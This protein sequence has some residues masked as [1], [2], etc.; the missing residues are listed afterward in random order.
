M[1]QEQLPEPHGN[2][3]LKDP[4]VLA[5]LLCGFFEPAVR[6]L[7]IMD[8]L[9]AV[10]QVQEIVG[11]SRLAKST[12][13][14]AIKRFD[15]SQ[16]QSV[17]RILQ[18][19]MSPLTQCDPELAGIVRTI[20]Q[21]GTSIRLAGDVAWAF[22]RRRD[23]KGRKDSQA[24]VHLQVD[25]QRWTMEDFR[26]TGRKD[27]SEQAAM[28]KMLTPGTLYLMDRGYCGFDL[29]NEILGQGCH[30]V[31]RLKKDIVFRPQQSRP[32]SEKDI[33][34]G[35]Q[36]DEL[37]YLGLEDEDLSPGTVRKN[38]PP[39]QLM[40]RVQV[41]DPLN[42][43]AVILITDLLVVEAWV[44]GGLYRSR[45]I[46]ELYLRWLKVT[47]GYAHLFSQSQN[48]VQL[49]MYVALIGTL[50]IHLRTGSPVS[51]YS[52]F[53]LG[54]VAAGRATYAELLPGI[55]RLEREHM[56]AKARLSRKKAEA[57]EKQ[58]VQ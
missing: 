43:K 5:M 40:R 49:Q 10:P 55:L 20:A 45:W 48:G 33:A 36:S 46:V 41:W 47:A 44:I 16:L 53:A 27:S 25:V 18:R 8:Q 23:T 28:K 4:M 35:V 3:Q 58:S 14:D 37:G 15:V 50:L 7:R 32:L 38:D 56:L 11:K 51:K 22:Q 2:T 9:S 19:R 54:L 52:L 21:D 57:A 13:S 30:L 6:S 42:K 29:Y 34:A 26:V 17:V 31:T 39:R 24:K 12:L 1:S